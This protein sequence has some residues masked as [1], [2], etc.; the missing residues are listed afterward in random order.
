MSDVSPG[1]SMD[2]Q[3]ILDDLIK[4]WVS[5]GVTF[6]SDAPGVT[7]LYVYVSSEQGSV[8]PEIFFEQDGHVLYASDVQGTDI[9]RERIHRMHGLQ[10]E[11]LQ[12]AEKR[13]DEIGVPRPTE[14]RIYYERATRKL[15]VQLSRELIYAN[16][17]SKVPEFGL[18]Y[19][20]GDRAPRLF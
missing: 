4:G 19:W 9:D 6:A 20:I 14:Y 13:F 17:P 18:V 16:E 10:F 7:A 5:L 8:Y 11:G 12:A 15:D 1:R 3:S 2:E